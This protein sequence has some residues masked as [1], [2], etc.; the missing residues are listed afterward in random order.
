MAMDSPR[1]RTTSLGDGARATNGAASGATVDSDLANRLESTASQWKEIDFPAFQA[2]AEAMSLQILENQREG[3]AGRK[4]LAELTRD[5]RKQDESTRLSQL[6]ALLKAYQK[7]I[8]A[9]TTR[10]KSVES[11]CLSTFA[12]W[13]HLPDVTPLLSNAATQL[14]TA[15]TLQTTVDQYEADMAQV[16]AQRER[17]LAKPMEDRIRALKDRETGL[18]RAVA[19]ADEANR[20]LQGRVDRQAALLQAETEARDCERAAHRQ[21]MQLLAAEVE[22]HRRR[23]R[24]QL[25]KQLDAS[26]TAFAT[27][28]KRM[29]DH[30]AMLEDKIATPTA[31]TPLSPTD[32]S[33]SRLVGILTAQR[34]RLKQRTQELEQVMLGKSQTITE[35]NSALERMQHENMTLYERIAYLS[36]YSAQG[37]RRSATPGGTGVAGAG[38]ASSSSGSVAVDMT[39]TSDVEQ[40][41]RTLYEEQ[42]NPFTEFA[43]KERRR[44]YL[45][46]GQADRFTLHITNILSNSSVARKALLGYLLALHLLIVFTCHVIASKS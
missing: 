11:F 13:T 8:D 9:L 7:E 1:M 19:K 40:K 6:G 18:E 29:Q 38:A 23:L 21:E 12:Q 37:G 2:S 3:A 36:S 5:F 44:R 20:D 10:S 27:E 25:R 46:L 26:R 15:A 24:Q 33:D 28:R 17:A 32:A 31:Q 35:L 30:I 43:R 34:D 42:L 45:Q 41:Y 16:L 39:G 22:T 4:H 14:Q